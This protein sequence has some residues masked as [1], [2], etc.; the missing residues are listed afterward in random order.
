MR[1]FKL[2]TALSLV[3]LM[4]LLAVLSLPIAAQN[5]GKQKTSAPPTP[6][7][8][9]TPAP[10]TEK[11]AAETKADDI[12]KIEHADL[13]QYDA[14]KEVYYLSGNVIFSHRDMK[15]HCDEAWYDE[16]KDTARATGH[17]RIVDPEATITG[18][19][20]AANF[21]TEVATLTGNVT[22]VAQKKVEK[23]K[24]SQNEQENLSKF[25]EYRRRKTTITC[26]KIVYQYNDKIKKIILSGPVKA[27]Q[28]DKT[29]WADNA[30]YEELTDIIILTGNVR[31]TTQKGEEFRAPEV[32]I[33]VEEE[34][35]KAKNV[36][37]ITFRQREETE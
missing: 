9:D 29:A 20:A 37:G 23:A 12:V 14:T 4:C 1:Y 34:W 25:E 10:E 31:V 33:A 13:L 17:L 36:S 19:V 16:A 2:A 28:E 3:L 21:N 5:A 26:P 15:M 18:D 22:V 35:M 30:V 11:A 8:L 7:K 27:V 32:V 6:P 24:N